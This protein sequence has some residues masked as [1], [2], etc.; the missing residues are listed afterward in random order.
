MIPE[1]ASDAPRI[2]AFVSGHG[3]GHAARSSATL[4]ELHRVHACRVELFTTAPRWFFEESISGVFHYHREV[5][6]VGFR[7]R[8]ALRLD[9]DATVEALRRFVPFEPSKVERL[10]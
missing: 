7:Q 2:A 10:A 9:V 1:D 6:D 4:A 8:S 5:V 3:F